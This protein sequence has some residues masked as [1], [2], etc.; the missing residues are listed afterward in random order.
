[1]ILYILIWQIRGSP[2][3]PF[4]IRI[5]LKTV[6]YGGYLEMATVDK[7]SGLVVHRN[8]RQTMVVE[9]PVASSLELGSVSKSDWRMFE[10]LG[11]DMVCVCVFPT[12][13]IYDIYAYAC[14]LLSTDS[15]FDSQV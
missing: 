3:P 2:S 5:C 9:L 8:V 12:Y 4:E 10:A 15:V 11:W 13:P 14:Q 7:P 6:E 1:M